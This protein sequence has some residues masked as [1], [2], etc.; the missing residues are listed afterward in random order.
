MDR[1][2][3]KSDSN[4][5]R[6]NSNKPGSSKSNDDSNTTSA[7]ANDLGM[8]IFTPNTSFGKLFYYI[9]N[10]IFGTFFLSLGVF[11]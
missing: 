3:K 4:D 9:R 6:E 1:T 11:F 10:M 2:H 7:C 5:T 8:D